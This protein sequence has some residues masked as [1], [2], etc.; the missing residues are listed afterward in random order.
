MGR[1][2]KSCSRKSTRLAGHSCPTVAGAFLLARSALK[3]LYPDSLPQRGGVRIAM[4]APED[5][6]TTGVVA[7]VLTLVTGAASRGGFFGI[8]GRYSRRQLLVFAPGAQADERIRFTRTDSGRTVAGRIDLS[9]LP[10]SAAQRERMPAVIRGQADPSQ[11]VA[12]GE[13]WQER[14]CW[15]LLDHADDPAVIQIDRAPEEPPTRASGTSA[16]DCS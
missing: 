10:V 11:Q 14:V 3:S 7:Q 16:R 9:T 5:E 2:R 13:A 4:P 1:T 8:G 6:G 12:F 15:L